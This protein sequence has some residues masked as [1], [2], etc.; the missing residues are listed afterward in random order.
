MAKLQS[1]R[2]QCGPRPAGLDWSITMPI[3]HNDKAAAQLVAVLFLARDLAHRAH[4]KVKGKGSFAQ[5]AGALGD[6]YPK[7]IDFADT[8][9]ECYQGRTRRL[10]D[11]PLLDN[12]FPGD[13]KTSMLA[14]QEWIEENRYKAIP[15]D[16]TPLQNLIDEIV[17]LYLGTIYKLE[18]LE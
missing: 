2:G 9:T 8:L 7:V 14:Q 1:S 11:I 16:D 3:N 5:H 4:L 13:I 15:K 12:E 10:L 18:F 17:L 6:F